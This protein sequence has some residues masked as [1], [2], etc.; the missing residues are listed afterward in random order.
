MIWIA[1]SFASLVM[2][3]LPFGR[4]IARKVADIDIT[5]RGSGNIGA[6]NVARE[7]GLKWGVLTLILDLL[8]GFVPVFVLSHLQPQHQLGHA[9]VGLAALVGHQ[10][11]LFQGFSG[12]KGVATALGVYLVLAPLPALIAMGCF[13]LTVIIFDFVSLGSI[14]S[15]G[16]MPVLLILSG[17]S[18][19]MVF[20]SCLVTALIWIKHRG[21]MRRLLRGEERKWRRLT[22]RSGVPTSDQTPR[23]NRS[24]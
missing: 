19:T 20:A 14:I 18:L 12:G 24:E 15:A 23:Q 8:K 7:L 4:L 9:L 22:L 1:C 6:T 16:L 10:F 2:G 21:N 11:S 5:Q 3:S 13:A 17:K